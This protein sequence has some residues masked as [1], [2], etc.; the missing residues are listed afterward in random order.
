MKN[1][2]LELKIKKILK[3]SGKHF[4]PYKFIIREIIR[5]HKDFDLLKNRKIIELGPGDNFTL[6]N[7]LSQYTFVE[8][9]G[10]SFALQNK[11]KYLREEY[12]H[13]YLASKKANS[14]D[15]IYSRIVMEEHSFEAP[16]L[17]QSDIYKRLMTEGPSHN[18]WMQY[19]GSLQYI[20]N[21]Y[22]EIQRVLKTGGIIISHVGNRSKSQ[23]H[24]SYFEQETGLHLEISY[25]IRL[26]GQ[27]WVYRK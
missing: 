20:M 13:D 7:Y 25:P 23:F 24:N 6:I 15:L 18:L 11:P 26:F 27:M 19:P 12:I 21:C 5:E 9:A 14:V 8:A 16:L 1:R 4:R 22:K 3:D 17:L 10:L 2:R